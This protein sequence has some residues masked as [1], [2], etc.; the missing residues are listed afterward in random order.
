LRSKNPLIKIGKIVQAH[1]LKGEVKVYLFSG[2]ASWYKQLEFIVL[3]GDESK[4]I[5]VI[6]KTFRND[7]LVL[8]LKGVDDRNSSEALKG[9]E[10]SILEELLNSKK[11]EAVFLRELLG[12]KVIDNGLEVGTVSG[13]ESTNFQDIIIIDLINSQK[14]ALVPLVQEFLV[15]TDFE[16]K[17]IHMN[18]PTGLLEVNDAL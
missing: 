11:G 18:L 12:F 2:E 13:F 10:V 7:R 16:K 8:K 6:T 9:S 5:E 1:G 14:K 3:N 4:P 15:K 17:E